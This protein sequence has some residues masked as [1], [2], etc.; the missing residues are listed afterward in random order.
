MT[1]TFF[2]DVASSNSNLPKI[3]AD[4]L[5]PDSGLGVDLFDISHP[6]SLRTDVIAA[7]TS[8]YNLNGDTTYSS[9]LVP[10]TANASL[11]TDKTAI[12]LVVASAANY[13][14]VVIPGK[15]LVDIYAQQKFI[16]CAYLTLPS[17]ANWPSGNTRIVGDS[18]NVTNGAVTIMLNKSGSSPQIAGQRLTASGGAVEQR[19]F[20]LD[21]SYYGA[22]VQ[23]AVYRTATEW[24]FTIIKQGAS[25]MTSTL[26]Q[27]GLCTFDY[28]ARD[29]LVGQCN[30][31]LSINVYRAFIENLAQT[32]RNPI[33]VLNADWQRFIA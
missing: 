13:A 30:I 4:Q 28:S 31:T 3:K 8:I 29:I 25:R 15:P 17:E 1:V 18:A 26:A 23:V 16:V 33:D 19:V 22:V 7:G 27:G 11:N 9:L 21:S 2:S 24:G 14:G 10:S 5:I 12:S 32:L 6:Y 20:V